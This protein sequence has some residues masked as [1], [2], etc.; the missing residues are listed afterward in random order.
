MHVYWKQENVYI[1]SEY[2]EGENI[3]ILIYEDRNRIVEDRIFY[4]ANGFK[5]QA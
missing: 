4:V 5:F 1:S 2:R 3:R